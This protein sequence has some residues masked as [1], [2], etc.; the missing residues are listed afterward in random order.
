MTISLDAPTDSV[1]RRHAMTERI[2]LVGQPP[3][4]S[5]LKR[6]YEHLCSTLTAR[7]GEMPVAAA[8]QAPR[9]AAAAAPTPVAAS[10][11]RAPA[12]ATAPASAQPSR[13]HSQA[14]PAASQQ[15]APGG[16]FAWFKRLLGM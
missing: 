15:P 12:P 13:P 6:H 7:G 5:V 11:T 4:D 1:L 2:R 9:V 10:S 16:F 8:P 3:T 14:Q